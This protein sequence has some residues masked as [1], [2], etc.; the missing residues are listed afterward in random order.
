MRAELLTSDKV[1]ITFESDDLELLNINYRDMDYRNEKVQRIFWRAIYFARDETGFDPTG[2]KLLLEAYPGRDGG[3]MLYVTR[4]YKKDQ[5]EEEPFADDAAETC[6]YIYRFHTIND[7]LDCCHFFD[8]PQ[9]SLNESA[10][11]K[12][13]DGYYLRFSVTLEMND[14]GVTRLLKNLSE[15][16]EKL[17][18]RYINSVMEEHYQ[19]VIPNAALAK[20]QLVAG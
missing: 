2:F 15:Y 7:L 12:H 13:N 11:Y 9:L 18:G 16:G 14:V 3:Y 10:L 5:S 1:K 19:V 4:L 6:S 17:S 8:N 20:L